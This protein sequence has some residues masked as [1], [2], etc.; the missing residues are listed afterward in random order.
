MTKILIISKRKCSS[1]TNFRSK[2]SKIEKQSTKEKEV[3]P[4]IYRFI[5]FNIKK[6]RNFPDIS[7]PKIRKFNI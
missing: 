2:L 5:D 1:E 4:L 6:Q 3:K 7:V